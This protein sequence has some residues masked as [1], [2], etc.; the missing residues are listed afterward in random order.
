MKKVVLPV[1]IEALE[2][3]RF[4]AICDAIQGLHAEGDTVADALE[5]LEDAARVLLEVRKEEGLPPP[6]GLAE[7]GPEAVFAAQVVVAIPE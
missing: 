7:L 3:G 6:L 1:E 4:F 5:N 2:D